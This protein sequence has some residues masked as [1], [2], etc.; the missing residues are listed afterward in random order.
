METNNGWTVIT[1]DRLDRHNDHIQIYSKRDLRGGILLSDLGE[2]MTDVAQSG[3]D[4]DKPEFQARI[5]DALVLL[6][7]D[8]ELDGSLV[9]HAS[10]ENFSES[11]DRLARAIV[12]I[13]D[14][15][16]KEISEHASPAC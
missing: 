1:T 12:A 7:V 11:C 15:V 8:M 14:V 3:C 6:D 16:E 9:L 10:D 4:E 5:D 13:N 2:T